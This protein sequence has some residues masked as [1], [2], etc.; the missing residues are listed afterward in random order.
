MQSLFWRLM[1]VAAFKIK[2]HFFINL[3]GFTVCSCWIRKHQLRHW[4]KIM[5]RQFES[6][7]VF[8]PFLCSSLSW[9]AW[10][11]ISGFFFPPLLCFHLFYYFFDFLPQLLQC[12]EA[13]AEEKSCSYP[14]YFFLSTIAGLVSHSTATAF[15]GNAQFRSRECQ[16]SPALP[17]GHQKHSPTAQILQH[18]LLDLF[19]SVKQIVIKL[20]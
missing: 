7:L 15:P 20:Q 8:T 16:D 18:P 9:K 6:S 11:M 14:V 13:P 17:L 12:V 2:Y 5:F 3:Y 4:W 10:Q 1:T 19:G